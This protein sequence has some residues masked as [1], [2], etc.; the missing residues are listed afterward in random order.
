MKQKYEEKAQ[1]TKHIQIDSLWTQKSNSSEREAYYRIK[2]L[3]H[4][5]LSSKTNLN[6]VSDTKGSN[7]VNPR[8]SA[9]IDPAR[10]M[11]DK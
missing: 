1:S 8:L 10:I 2:I 11:A 7:T 5:Q 6:S 3:V 4:N 9:T